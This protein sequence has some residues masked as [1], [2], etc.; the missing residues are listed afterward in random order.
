MS[1]ISRVRPI[2]RRRSV[3][4]DTVARRNGERLIR[5]FLAPMQGWQLELAYLQA[6]MSAE[7]VSKEDIEQTSEL[8][9]ALLAE[10]HEGLIAFE[11]EVGEDKSPPVLVFRESLLRLKSMIADFHWTAPGAPPGAG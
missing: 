1:P 5:P 8:A 3:S 10:V 9:D 2:H 7:R 4:W 11:H 6:K